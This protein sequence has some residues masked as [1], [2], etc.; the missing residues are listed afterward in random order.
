MYT[1]IS[2]DPFLWFNDRLDRDLQLAPLKP[3]RNPTQPYQPP[4][5]PQ[6]PVKSYLHP[7]LAMAS[8]I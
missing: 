7:I 4:R 8:D 3:M 2:V 5:N 1:Y 6:N